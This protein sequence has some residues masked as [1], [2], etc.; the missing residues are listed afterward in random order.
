[1]QLEFP[2]QIIYLSKFSKSCAPLDTENFEQVII[3]ANLLS[4]IYTRWYGI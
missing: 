3:S 2:C 1:M 4:L